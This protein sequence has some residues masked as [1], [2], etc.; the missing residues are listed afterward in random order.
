MFLTIRV[1]ETAEK[2]E[3]AD[4]SARIRGI[5]T[6]RLLSKVLETVL[7]DQLILPILDDADHLRS[8]MP[9]Y[10]KYRTRKHD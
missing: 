5:S 7:E 3:Y 6:T 9:R 4:S 2:R 10:S 8:E 1:A